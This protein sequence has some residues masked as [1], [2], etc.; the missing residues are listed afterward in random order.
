M[1]IDTDLFTDNNIPSL[2]LCPIGGGVI[3]RMVVLSCSQNH[4]N[5]KK[6]YKDDDGD[7][8]DDDDDYGY[9][10]KGAKKATKKVEINT[11]NYM[12]IFCEDCLIKALNANNKCPLCNCKHKIS[13]IMY[14]PYN[15]NFKYELS[16]INVK[17]G[18]KWHNNLDQFETHIL[19]CEFNKINC[20][21]CDNSHF[22]KDKEHHEKNICNY[23]REQCNK[24]HHPYFY[25]DKNQHEKII[26]CLKCKIKINKCEL[27]NHKNICLEEIVSC[28]FDKCDEKIKRCMINDHLTSAMLKHMLLLQE[29]YKDAFS[30]N[31]IK[32]HLYSEY[33]AC[34]T[35][36]LNFLNDTQPKP[37]KKSKKKLETKQGKKSKAEAT[38]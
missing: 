38:W 6:S 4:E 14:M 21:R 8:D 22:V 25:K 33:C 9:K 31:I 15:D 18:C 23:R 20:K 17:E 24:C 11:K 1:C 16:C 10:K 19:K 32:E 37:E 30:D 34:D 35:C 26:E 12:H 2:F 29:Q 7:D 5:S 13:D 3:D 27:E 36:N 28:P